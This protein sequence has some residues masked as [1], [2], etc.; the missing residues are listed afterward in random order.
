MDSYPEANYILFTTIQ[1]SIYKDRVHWNLELIYEQKTKICCSSY[2]N[3][4]F[5]LL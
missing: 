1:S 2:N 5:F 3:L 4:L